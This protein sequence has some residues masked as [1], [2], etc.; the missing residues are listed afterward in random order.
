MVIYVWSFAC[1]EVRFSI[2]KKTEKSYIRTF[3]LSLSDL[4]IFPTALAQ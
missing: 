1:C 3:T 4:S 2:F